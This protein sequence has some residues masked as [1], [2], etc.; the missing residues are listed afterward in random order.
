M[1]DIP[2][3]TNLEAVTFSPAAS[4]RDAMKALDAAGTGALALCD[5]QG[6]LV[7]ML[8]DGDLRR[9]LLRGQSLED[10]CSVV[11]CLKPVF[12]KSPVTAA[13]ALQVMNEFDIHQLPV[14]DDQGVLVN[15]LLRKDVVEE[16]QL[17]VESRGRLRR[18]CIAPEA[19]IADAIAQL[20]QAGTGALVLRDTEGKLCGLITDGDIRRA[21]IRRIP[22]SEPCESIATPKPVCASEPISSSDALHIMNEHDIHQLPLVDGEGR[23]VD[24][25]LRKDLLPQTQHDLQ[26]VI[27]AGGYGKRLLPL[28][29]TVPKP[30]LPVGERPLLEHIIQQL[31]RAGIHDVNLTTHYLPESI[32]GHFGNGEHFGVRLNY[33]REE[34]PLGTAGGLRLMPRPQGPFLVIN[35]DILTGVPFQQMLQY[36]RSHR[37]MLTV[38]V[39][40]YEIQVPFGVVDCDDVRITKIEEKPCHSYFINAGTYLLDPSAW[41]RIPEGTRFDM[42]DLIRVLLEAGETVVGFPIMEYW[43][44]VGRHEDYEKAQELVLKGEL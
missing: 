2:N 39:R 26:A 17:E 36:H 40:K 21:V 3:M 5:E 42:T 12:A 11:A 10:A 37:A 14:V 18:V 15:L 33:S 20:N 13:H 35:G 44:D 1:K 31:R 4:I 30:M 28:T 27:M 6:K 7:A 34:N 23:I 8:S 22:L 29:E 19:S 16:F 43:I 25:L 9:A 32:S 41:D 38:G 24:F